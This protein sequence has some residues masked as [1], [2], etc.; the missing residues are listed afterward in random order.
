ML[1]KE[2]DHDPKCPL[3]QEQK[4]RIVTLGTGYTTEEK[5][6]TYKLDDRRQLKKAW[7]K[8]MK[9]IGFTDAQIS[10]MTKS[11]LK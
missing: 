5:T 6:G 2:I 1:Y 11:V 8:Y 9:R 4:A 3:V 10:Y 7:G